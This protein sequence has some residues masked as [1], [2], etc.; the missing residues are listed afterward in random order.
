MAVSM[1][2]QQHKPKPNGPAVRKTGFQGASRSV[3][4]SGL[5]GI[6]I[7]LI[8][9]FLLVFAVLEIKSGLRAY[10]TGES[11][12][13]KGRQ[14]AVYYL[15][16][17][18]ASANPDDLAQARSGL[19]IPLGDLK[20]R[21]ALEQSSPDLAAAREG[22]LQGGNHPNDITRLIWL[23]QYFEE[24]NYFQQSMDIWRRTD[25]HIL[26]LE[27]LADMLEEGRLTPN[28]LLD[29]RSEIHDING[30]LSDLEMEFSRTLGEADRWLNGILLIIVLGILALTA[31]VAMSLFWWFAGRMAKSERELRATLEHAG[32]G[33]A[34]ISRAG[35]IQSINSRLCR[36]L[37]LEADELIGH[38]LSTLV[39]QYSEMASSPVNLNRLRHQLDN[40]NREITVDQP[41]KKGNDHLWLRYTFSA[42]KDRRGRTRDYILVAED[43]SEDRTRVDE[44][45]Y[46]ATHDALTGL[47]NRREFKRRLNIVI[48]IAQ[49]ENAHHVL[50]FF[51]L[52][53]F[54]DVNDTCGHAAGDEC[55]IQLCQIL[56]TQ[57]REGDILARLGGDEFALILYYCPLEVAEKIA[58]QL[59]RN[60]ER[61]I[62]HWE[63]QSFQL[64]AS[65]G[66]AELS[67]S[68]DDAEAVLDAADRGCYEAKRGG[69]NS[70][71]VVDLDHPELPA[72]RAA[73]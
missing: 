50:C 21:L 59:R 54:K 19:A 62:F 56:R 45:T 58:E 53:Y 16:R 7:F 65:I 64:S 66:I 60:V 70:V 26:R 5:G 73:Q 12:W 6:L 9:A 17:Y 57:L 29:I 41:W 47:I 72:R 55:L 39:D 67:G 61:F 23:F 11:Y 22:F 20:A 31:V 28:Q 32:V 3:M 34:R 63:G 10:V 2:L 1:R 71:Y 48:D 37:G 69:R 43:I 68:L 8:L 24:V 49:S 35:Y 4:V 40:G 36:T 33:M 15:D 38:P 27:S 44:L 13:S 52:D 46:E 25:N 18:A 14:D 30:L 51:D 42:I